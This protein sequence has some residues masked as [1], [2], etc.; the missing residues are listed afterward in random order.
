[1]QASACNLSRGVHFNPVTALQ[2]NEWLGALIE[3]RAEDLY[4]FK[5][6]L[7]I[8]DFPNR[9][10]FQVRT[11]FPRQMPHHVS[12]DGG[13]GDLLDDSRMVISGDHP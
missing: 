11:P 4:R 8:K 7:S 2:V 13:G 10:V 12:R 5:G 3:V 6:V 9:Y 1:M